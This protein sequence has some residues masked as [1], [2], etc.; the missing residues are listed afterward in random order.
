MDPKIA[1]LIGN[2]PEQ[3]G[4]SKLE[5]HADVIAELRRKRYTY[6]QIA[7]FIQE[8][9]NLSVAQSTIHD[10]VRVRRRRG[11]K[12]A[13]PDVPAAAVRPQRDRETGTPGDVQ[14]KIAELKR[15]SAPT[16]DNKPTFVY[17]AEQPLKLVK[18]RHEHE[19]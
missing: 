15:R 2:L 6:K 14:R 19:K 13:T 10:F 11:K 16:G 18:N 9:F 5:Q 1:A 17:D 12:T 7:Q 8:Q 3:P 4:R